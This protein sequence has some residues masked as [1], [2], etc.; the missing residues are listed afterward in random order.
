MKLTYL[1]RIVPREIFWTWVCLILGLILIYLIFIQ[2]NLVK[3]LDQ[4]ITFIIASF[5]ALFSIIQFWVS[6]IRHR[7]DFIK[8]MRYDE[9]KRIRELINRFFNSLSENMGEKQNIHLLSRQLTDIK[10]EL[11]VIIQMTN[12]SIFKGILENKSII[13]FGQKTDAI[14]VQTDKLRYKIDEMNEKKN[15]TEDVMQFAIGIEIMNW[16]NELIPII[17]EL[18][19]LKYRLFEFIEHRLI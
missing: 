2:K 18:H 4:K 8:M 1:K 10:N 11:V 19:I 16:H 15:V 13:E 9:Y 5:G 12:K 3:D 6:S 14:L 7:N 17:K